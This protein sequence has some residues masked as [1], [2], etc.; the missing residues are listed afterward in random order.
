MIDINLTGAVP[1]WAVNMPH[2]VRETAGNMPTITVRMMPWSDD[3]S[4]NRTKQYNAHTN[5]Y[6]ANT[7]LPHEKLQQ[8]Y[9]IQ[10]VSTSQYA[11][12]SEQ[13]RVISENT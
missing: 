3:V 2:P 13:M 9:F 8:E 6:M 10:F 5:V 1:G 11:S 12:S 4:G 7:N